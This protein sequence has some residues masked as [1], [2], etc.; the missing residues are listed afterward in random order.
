M[1]FIYS[2]YWHTDAHECFKFLM[3]VMGGPVTFDQAEL[4]V[5]AFVR[6]KKKNVCFWILDSSQMCLKCQKNEVSLKHG[7][8]HTDVFLKIWISIKGLI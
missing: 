5:T 8:D 3:S 2:M 7:T 6:L 1:L 4:I